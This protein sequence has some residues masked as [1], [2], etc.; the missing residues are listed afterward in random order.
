VALLPAYGDRDDQMPMVYRPWISP[1]GDDDFDWDRKKSLATFADRDFVFE[2]ARSVFRGPL[3]RRQDTRRRR[4]RE[5]RFMVL[6]EL[7]GRVMV[8]IHTPRN[9]KC[10]ITSL[11][12]ANALECEIH[13]EYTGG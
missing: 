13:Y 7:Y 3:V 8:I 5:P 11:R 10:R 1:Y 4:S 6:G 12:P 2:A 9:G